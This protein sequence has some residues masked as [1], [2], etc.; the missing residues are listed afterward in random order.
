MLDDTYK[1]Y[2]E[3]AS[4][5]PDWRTANK[6][7]LVRKFLELN[8]NKD[9][10]SDMYLAAV[11]L[12][13]WPKIYRMLKATPNVCTD[14]DVYDWLVEAIMNLANYSRPWDDPNHKLYNDPNAP[15]KC[16][17][18]MM[19]TTR[20]NY[21]I[22]INRKKRSANTL[23]LSLDQLGEDNGDAVDFD[24][25]YL[26]SLSYPLPE[27]DLEHKSILQNFMNEQK[28]YLFFIYYSIAV[29]GVCNAEGLYTEKALVKFLSNL[30]A[31][32][33]YSISS[34]TDIPYADVLYAYSASVCG[35]SNDQLY[36]VLRTALYQLKKLYYDGQV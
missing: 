9:P 7:D 6:S 26:S 36:S 25:D 11:M 34:F 12:R 18:R 16:I 27:E 22:Y 4:T 32:Q 15:D 5:V 33:L 2:L 31:D 13:Y 19:K 35:K 1:L 24:E 21:L 17:N 10:R 3:A 14:Q 20:L 23:A 30:D 29:Y 28:Y 8:D